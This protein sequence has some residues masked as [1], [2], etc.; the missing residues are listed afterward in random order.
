MDAGLMTKRIEILCPTY[1]RD[2]KG[3]MVR[4]YSSMATIW[5]EYATQSGREFYAAQKINPEITALF[6]IRPR[7]DIKVSWRIKYHYRYFDV[8][9]INDTVIDEYGLHC[10]E[11]FENI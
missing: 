8:T 11:L 4:T 6:K 5:A 3:G 10:K 2:A 1:A 7:T 9:F